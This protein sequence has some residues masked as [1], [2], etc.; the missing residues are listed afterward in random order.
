MELRSWGDGWGDADGSLTGNTFERVE[1][2]SKLYFELCG[3]WNTA[4]PRDLPVVDCLNSLRQPL[5]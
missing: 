3:I 1:N 2:T 5:A 4:Y